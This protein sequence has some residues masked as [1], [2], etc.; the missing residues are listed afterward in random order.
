MEYTDEK[1]LSEF[2]KPFKG[3]KVDFFRFNGNYGDSFI[4]HG[5]MK[6]LEQLNIIPNYVDINSRVENTTLLI[7]GGGNFVDYYSDVRDFLLKKKDLYQ[8]IIILPHTIYGEKQKQ[9]LGD[10]KPNVTIFCRERVSYDFVKKH[11]LNCSVY[12]WHDCAFYN[13]F[14]S[15]ISKGS[16]VLN[17]FRKDIESIRDEIPDDNIDVS[18]NGYAKKPLEIFLNKINEYSVVNTDRLHVG[19]VA[20]LLNKKV[21]LYPNSYF[22]NK[23]V[24]EYSMSK[25]P[26]IKLIESK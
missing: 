13:D 11:A 9:L 24:Y 5:T 26:N 8:K 7:D 4:W 1:D 2:L 3:F 10:L 19:I 15:F 22:K 16:G 14:S 23:A 17:A 21:N 20:T 6:L 12:L 18:L 25:F